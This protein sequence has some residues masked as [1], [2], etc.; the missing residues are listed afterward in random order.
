[1]STTTSGPHTTPAGEPRPIIPP[2]ASLYS[3]TR[4]LSWLVVRLTAGG[5]LLV[6]GIFK[7]M[8]M[9]EKGFTATIEAFAAGG[10]ARRGIEPS[11]PAAYAV[12]FIETIGAV[13]IMLGLFTRFIAAA[14]A[15]RVRNHHLRG[16]LGARLRLEPRR[17]GVPAVLG[18]SSSSP[19]HCAA[20]APIRST[21]SSAGSCRPS[22]RQQAAAYR[23]IQTLLSWK[24]APPKGA[25]AVVAGQGVDAAPS[26]KAAFGQIDSAIKTPRRT[27]SNS[28]A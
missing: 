20:A 22:R 28:R 13:M 26:A 15:F 6:H 24:A 9:A 23:R 1:M 21:A 17:L 25:I 11:I 12:F 19:S 18:L 4:D 16:A 10:L 5:M 2:L 27:P 14:A 7:V 3:H 8:P